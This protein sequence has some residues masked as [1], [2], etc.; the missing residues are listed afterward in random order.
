MCLDLNL[1][2]FSLRA[3]SPGRAEKDGELATSSLKFEF[4]LQFSCGSPSTELSDSRQS[5]RKPKRARMQT[6]I[7]KHVPRVM[8]SILVSSLPI[9]ISHRLFWC[10]YSNSRDVAASSPSFSHPAA[11]LSSRASS[12]AGSHLGLPKNNKNKQTNKKIQ[13]WKKVKW[14]LTLKYFK[15]LA[16]DTAN[17][18]SHH[19]LASLNFFNWMKALAPAT[20]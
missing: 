15:I 3:S 1:V 13:R 5:A 7:E 8:T 12:E 19:A 10:T 2:T 4:H 9:T 18:L 16:K 6:N 14:W 17:P 11:R 20:V